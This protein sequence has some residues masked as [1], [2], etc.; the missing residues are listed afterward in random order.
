MDFSGGN[1]KFG[2][3]RTSIFIQ[4]LLGG[5][6]LI[7]IA[8]CGSG[9]QPADADK[10]DGQTVA[11]AANPD[12]SQPNSDGT[13]AVTT[14]TNGGNTAPTSSGPPRREFKPVVL[15]GN[16][17]PAPA[18]NGPAKTG[19]VTVADV[20]KAIEPLN[21]LIGQ[22]NTTTRTKGAGEAEWII[23]PKTARTQPAL[24]M[25]ADGHPYFKEARLTFDVAKNVFRMNATDV[26]G[27]ERNYEGIYVQKPQLAPGDNGKLQ[28]TFKLRLDEVGNDDARKLVA[29]VFNQQENNRLL[30]EVHRRVGNRV[31]IQD[32]VANQRKNTSFALSDADYGDRECIVSQGLGTTAIT[33]MGR[34]YYVCCSGCDA[35]FKDN[36][37]YWITAAMERKEKGDDKPE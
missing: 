37:E 21:I 36:P 23:D 14:N 34:T 31:D 33:Y 15:G 2:V 16:A 18:G 1:R 35:A 10:G 5:A 20:F 13:P 30:M 8:G 25:A 3:V 29:V 12:T 24:K 6:L 26:D 7:G 11:P 32:T 28:R 9:D 19:M 4:G 17:N 27:Q 22:W